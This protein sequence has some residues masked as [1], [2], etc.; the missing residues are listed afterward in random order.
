MYKNVRPLAVTT[1]NPSQIHT[2]HSYH[3]LV[4]FSTF[5]LYYC[6]IFCE[7]LSYLY[8]ANISKDLISFASRN[9]IACW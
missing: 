8:P 1:S 2:L 4:I 3:N 6:K 9:P 7:D 5:P